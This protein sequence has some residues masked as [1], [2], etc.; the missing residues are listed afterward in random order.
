MIIID[1]PP[2]PNCEAVEMRVF[3]DLGP[4]RAVNRVRLEQ[5]PGAP[6]WYDVVG[7]TAAGA[8]QPARAVKVDDSGDGV[9]WLVYGGDAG[10]RLRPAGSTEGWRLDHPQ[11]WGLPFI[12]TTDAA[13]LQGEP[14]EKK[15]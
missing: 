14:P 4:S 12:L 7:W 15:T 1:I 9:V 5:A 13:D 10:L 11:Q 3:H 2:N 8:A 6:Q